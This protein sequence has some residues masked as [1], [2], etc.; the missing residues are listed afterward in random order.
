MSEILDE[1]GGTL[2]H[3]AARLVEASNAQRRK[4]ALAKNGE[5]VYSDPEPDHS[6]RVRA[7]ENMVALHGEP[8]PRSTS[9]APNPERGITVTA[10][11]PEEQRRL[12]AAQQAVEQLPAS[13]RM[14]LRE[15]F[16][17]TR[18]ITRKIL[19]APPDKE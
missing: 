10:T 8:R 3:C 5:F 7:V 18:A 6:V 9:A 15:A 2:E 1:R 11:A 13:E 17:R 14:Q 16:N 19:T 4:I 12:A